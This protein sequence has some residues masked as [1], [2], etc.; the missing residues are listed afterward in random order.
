MRA[1][2][3]DRRGQNHR[4]VVAQSYR[5]RHRVAS[6]NLWN[7][8]ERVFSDCF[9]ISGVETA[10]PDN[11]ENAGLKTDEIPEQELPGE[12]ESL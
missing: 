7:T 3:E 11:F 1:I 6:C 8:T 4:K 9:F 12:P 10:M 5:A 2:E